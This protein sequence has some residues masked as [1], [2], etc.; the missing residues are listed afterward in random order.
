MRNKTVAFLG[1]LCALA[2]SSCGAAAATS[3]RA[4]ATAAASTSSPAH[5]VPVGPCGA[6]SVAPSASTRIY[7]S[8]GSGTVGTP[9]KLTAV[10]GRSGGVIWTASVPNDSDGQLALAPDGST[11]YVLTGDHAVGAR[12]PLNSVTPVDLSAGNVEPA[13]DLKYSNGSA[14]G[15]AITPDGSKLYVTGGADSAAHASDG[16]AID[17]D[18]RTHAIVKTIALRAA[19]AQSQVA[20]APNGSVVYVTQPNGTELSRIAVPTDAVLPPFTLAASPWGGA[21]RQL[22][23]S[24]D[25]CT[26]YAITSQVITTVDLASGSSHGL[27]ALAGVKDGVTSVC[28]S[29]DSKTLFVTDTTKKAVLRIDLASGVE[30][31]S[32]LAGLYPFDVASTTDATS[33]LVS[34]PVGGTVSRLPLTGAGAKLLLTL[35][36]GALSVRIYVG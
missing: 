1:L 24:P 36:R 10:D 23:L 4:P 26:A 19:N 32:I 27:P 35:P 11:A 20:V 22:V 29:V 30:G 6:A 12:A 13:I 25:G 9:G 3:S 34:D 5:S 33:I 7:L 28:L 14:G 21:T 8:E 31:T 2:A 15:I 18:A 16:V 17:V